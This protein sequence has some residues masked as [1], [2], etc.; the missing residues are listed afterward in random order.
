MTKFAELILKYKLY[1]PII[2]RKEI[3]HTYQLYKGTGNAGR[4]YC[5]IRSDGYFFKRVNYVMAKN[6]VACNKCGYTFDAGSEGYYNRKT[7]QYICPSCANKLINS[8]SKGSYIWKAATDMLFKLYFGIVFLNPAINSAGESI[9]DTLVNA[10]IGLV[11]IGWAV[12]AFA[13]ALKSKKVVP[14]I[15]EMLLKIIM[16]MVFF[17]V[18]FDTESQGDVLIFIILGCAIMVWGLLPYIMAKK[19]EREIGSLICAV[20]ETEANAAKICPHCGATS[21]GDRCEYCGSAF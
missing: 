9:E 7:R 2:Q 5:L 20:V 17:A 12:L 4:L 3:S 14:S 6:M 19:K 1:C 8:G 16:G 21:K 13:E 15:P 10:I 11:L 18:S